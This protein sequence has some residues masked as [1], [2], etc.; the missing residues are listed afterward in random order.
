MPNHKIANSTSSM[1]D[2]SPLKDLLDRTL[3]LKANEER[4]VDDKTFHD[5]IVQRMVKANWVLEVKAAPVAA[6]PALEAPP[7]PEAPPAP[8]A[9]ETPPPAEPA[10]V[11]EPLVAEPEP[12]PMPVETP[13]VSETP[14]VEPPASSSSNKANKNRR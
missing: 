9:S 10:H 5:D 1:L 12:V 11:S 2:M 13:V 7:V 4:E 6:P 3:T 14:V 8:A